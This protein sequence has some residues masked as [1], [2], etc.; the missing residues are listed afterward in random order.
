MQVE[1][2]K[3]IAQVN[4]KRMKNVLSEKFRFAIN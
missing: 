4:L 2:I 1:E 3:N